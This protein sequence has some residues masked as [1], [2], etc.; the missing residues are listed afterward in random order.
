MSNFNNTFNNS[1][2]FCEFP[3][4]FLGYELRHTEEAP[5]TEDNRI[6]TDSDNRITAEGD[7]RT[8]TG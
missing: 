6:T 3:K 5:P 7:N 1:F 2:P 8:T 4:P